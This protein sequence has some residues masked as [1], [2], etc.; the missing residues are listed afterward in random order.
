[1]GLGAGYPLIC[2]SVIEAASPGWGT[3]ATITNRIP[4]NKETLTEAIKMIEDMSLRGLAGQDALDLGE[5]GVTGE[6]ETDLRYTLKSGNFFC[7]SDLWLAAAMGGSPLINASYVSTL[8]HTESP[9]RPVTIVFDKKVSYWEFVSCMFKGFKISGKVGEELKVSFP[10]VCH[11]LLRTGTTNG[12]TQFTNLAANGGKRVLFPDLTFRIG[13]AANA[14]AAGD[15]LGINEFTLDF[16]S[17][18]SDP[19]YSTPDYATTVGAGTHGDN[20]TT[21]AQRLTLQPAR[22][23]KRTVMLDFTLPRYQSDALSA[24]CEAGTELQVDIKSS[25][26]SAARTFS[27]LCPRVKL[28]KV[29]APVDSPAMFPVKVKARLLYNGGTSSATLHND[30]MTNSVTTTNK[31]PDEFQIELLNSTDGRTAV[32]W[33]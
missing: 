33:S 5:I 1:M 3:A 15:A 13:D 17:N 11:R 4:V 30:Y 9:T 31:I 12:A 22:N 2:G 26:D 25:I 28:E 6:I 20:A 14:L 27:I 29:D 16:N 19:E 21:H 8:L 10:V 7:G 24:W 23:G 32:I 18:L